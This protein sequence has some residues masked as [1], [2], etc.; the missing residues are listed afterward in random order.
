MH[1]IFQ[2]PL[3]PILWL[4]LGEE[5]FMFLFHNK[6]LLAES[7]MLQYFCVLFPGRCLRSDV[8]SDDMMILG[9]KWAPRVTGDSWHLISN[10]LHSLLSPNKAICP[11]IGQ[12]CS[13]WNT[14]WLLYYTTCQTHNQ[15]RQPLLVQEN[16]WSRHIFGLPPNVFFEDGSLSGYLSTCAVFAEW[17]GE[18]LAR[19][20]HWITSLDISKGFPFL[21]SSSSNWLPLVDS[22]KPHGIF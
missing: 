17:S 7:L 13:L 21:F 22:L 18:R 14:F 12:Q 19:F 8:I 20:F 9:L 16:D 2:F 10:K 5:I 3:L 6:P 15:T 4:I 11:L 1:L